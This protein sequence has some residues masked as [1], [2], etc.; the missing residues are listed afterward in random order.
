V[1]IKIGKQYLTPDGISSHILCE[2]KEQISK[3][4]I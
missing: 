1:S 3:N 2:L 4:L